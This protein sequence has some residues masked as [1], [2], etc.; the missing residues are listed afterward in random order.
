MVPQIQPVSFDRKT[1]EAFL[2]Q[3]EQRSSLL[4]G[5]L[6]LDHYV[7]LELLLCDAESKRMVRIPL[8]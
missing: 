2:Q 7:R 6:V 3:G 8:T 5:A 1:P 4:S